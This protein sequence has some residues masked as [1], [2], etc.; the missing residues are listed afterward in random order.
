MAVL[1]GPMK[2]VYYHAE[3]DSEDRV[4]LTEGEAQI[5]R[6]D[7]CQ[8]RKKRSRRTRKKSDPKT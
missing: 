5:Y 6:T 7:P 2:E 1:E 4:Q 3:P 8:T